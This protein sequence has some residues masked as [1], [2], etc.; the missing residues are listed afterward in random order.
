MSR[1]RNTN[2]ITKKAIK[3]YSLLLIVKQEIQSSKYFLFRLIFYSRY[4]ITVYN[5]SYGYVHRIK[6]ACKL[7][8][9]D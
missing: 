5:N 4:R 2:E 3:T 8:R 6:N 7:T 1:N 9:G